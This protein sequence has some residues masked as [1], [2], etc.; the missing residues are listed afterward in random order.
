MDIIARGGTNN[1]PASSKTS[2]RP[3]QRR[4]IE[5][6]AEASSPKR[7]RKTS[8][9]YMP[10]FQSGAYAIVMTLYNENCYGEHAKWMTK[11]EI[12]PLAKPLCASSF[13]R[14]SGKKRL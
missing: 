4:R 6:D 7:A 3:A 11:E 5:P 10:R 2:L 1:T 14:E 13:E 12:V 8:R 9:E